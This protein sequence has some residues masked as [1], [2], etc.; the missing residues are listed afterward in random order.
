MKPPRSWHSPRAE[1]QEVI[2]P[3]QDKSTPK[4]AYASTSA[5]LGGPRHEQEEVLRRFN[6]ASRAFYLLV[7]TGRPERL[8]RIGELMDDQARRLS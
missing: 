3:V 7:D 4:D 2:S 5:K 6:D 8:A 1:T